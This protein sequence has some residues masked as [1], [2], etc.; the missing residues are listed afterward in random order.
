MVGAVNA[1][2]TRANRYPEFLP[3]QLP[4]LIAGHLGI[5]RASG[6]RLRGH[7]STMQ[8]IRALTAPGSELVTAVPTFDG[9]PIM[10]EMARLTFVPVSL[11]HAGGCDLRATLRALTA[12]T[13][14]V[15]LCRP[16]NPT[17][18][19]IPAAELIA[20]LDLI[21][22]HTTVVLDEAYG[23][24][25]APADRLDHAVLL[26][27]HPNLLFL[28]TFSKAYSLAG[29]RIGYTFGHPDRIARI[30]RL[31]LP[32]G[33]S[34]TATAAVAA[35]YA[36]TTEL[37][38]RIRHI[39]AERDRLHTGRCRGTPQSRQLPLSPWAGEG[40][41]AASSRYRREALSRRQ[42]SHRGRRPRGRASCPRGHYLNAGPCNRYG[43]RCGL[44]CRRVPG[45]NRSADGPAPAGNRPDAVPAT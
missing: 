29:L 16:H 21:P 3:R 33:V 40:G 1:A 2:L 26:R 13:A 41:S 36:A 23:E 38:A 25:L 27:Q 37:E 4:K 39:G 43:D 32:F 44:S 8:I 22:S 11:D 20:F 24:F 30:H 10:A 34:V 18:T 28:R 5:S 15:V 35:S 7:R 42:C 45:P 31:Q 17:G 9:Y 6:R 14:L 12:R 19:V